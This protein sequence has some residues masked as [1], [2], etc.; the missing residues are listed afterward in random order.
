MYQRQK[1]PTT[2]PECQ[3][4]KHNKIMDSCIIFGAS[5]QERTQWWWSING[6]SISHCQ[7]NKTEAE[8]AK[9]HWNWNCSSG[10][11]YACR[12]MNPYI[13]WALKHMMIWRTLLIKTI[14]VLLFWGRTVR[15][16]S[17]S[18]QSTLFRRF[19]DQLMGVI[20]AHDPGPVNHKKY[21]EDKVSKYVHKVAVNA[22][23][24]H[25]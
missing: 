25:K 22:A 4:K 2:Y 13:G 14:K 20:E 12:T 8:H 15:I 10:L 16:Q 9:L 17:V 1:G 19:Q 21:C 24:T 7:F 6:K 11:F 23:P 3:K 5:K 18:A